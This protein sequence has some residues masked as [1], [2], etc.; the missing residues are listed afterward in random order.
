MSVPESAGNC[1]RAQALMS[2]SP[3]STVIFSPITTL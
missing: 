3:Q 2:V 1:A